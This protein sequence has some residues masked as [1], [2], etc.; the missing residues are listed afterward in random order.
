MS[1]ILNSCS[2]FQWG[3]DIVG[4]FPKSKGQMQYIV[5]ANDYATKWV[6]AKPLGRIRENDVIEF[7][8]EFIVFRFGIP[9]IV[10]TDN[11]T[12]FVG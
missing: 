6:E 9:R 10:V 1:P 12:Q 3:L 2:F 8:M 7:F 11:G 5:V 4:P